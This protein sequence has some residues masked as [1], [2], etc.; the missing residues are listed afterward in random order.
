MRKLLLIIAAVCAYAQTTQGPSRGGG[1]GG[2]SSCG[3]S[4][5]TACFVQTPAGG[6]N[7]GLLAGTQLVGKFQIS[8]GTNAATV[9][10]NG[11]LNIN[12]LTGCSGGGGG[13][14]FLDSAAF[15]AGSTSVNVDAGVFNDGLSALSSG[16][17]GAPRITSFRAMHIN[18]RNNSGTEIATAGA[19]L[20]V[21]PT[22]TTTQP[23]SAAS[24]PLPTGAALDASVTGL[25]VAQGST[26]AGQTGDLMQGAVTASAP[27]YT[28]GQTSPISLTTAGEVRVNCTGCS[29]ASTVTA[30]QGT[31]NTA[32][33][34]WPVKLTDGTNIQAV[35][36]ASTAAVATDPAA[37]VALSPNS[38]DRVVGNS[39]AVFDAANNAAAPANVLAMGFES[40]DGT[41][42]PTASTTGNMRRAVISTD[43]VAYT[44]VGG[45]VIWHC[46]LAGIAATLTQCQAAPAAGLSLYITGIKVNSTTSAFGTYQLQTGTGTNCGT[47]TAAF[48]PQGTTSTR[49]TS[50]TG[51]NPGQISFLGVPIKAPAASAICLIGAAT[52]TIEL[53]LIGYTAP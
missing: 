15:T 1:G 47:G 6:F 53:T 11:G 3:S 14:S 7:V 52:N 23:I 21:D 12:C 41:A 22:G 31:A 25:H 4:S 17:A 10:A 20:R 26:T 42:Q 28:N 39:G 43:G 33:N 9:G 48:Y 8:D 19:P 29:S 2:G 27:T 32:S 51:N 38:Q 34:G 30:N 46:E 36:A 35:K 45:P 50:A 24:L 37:V 5:I 16:Q 40:S 44:R 18:L 13:G 49:F